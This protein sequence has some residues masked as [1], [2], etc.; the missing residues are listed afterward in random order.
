M[1]R[2]GRTAAIGVAHHMMAAGDA[3]QLEPGAL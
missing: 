2:D 3:G 1:H